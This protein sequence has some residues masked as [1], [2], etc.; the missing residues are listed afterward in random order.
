M[1]KVLSISPGDVQMR[2]TEQPANTEDS[3]IATQTRVPPDKAEETTTER[4]SIFT[5]T[6]AR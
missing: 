3:P 1:A 6:R 2:M 4:S 5:H